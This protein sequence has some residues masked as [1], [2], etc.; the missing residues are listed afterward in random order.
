MISFADCG[1][2]PSVVETLRLHGIKEATPVQER[3]IPEVRAGRDVI[4]QAQTGTGKTL[5]FLLPIFEKIKAQADVAQA[6][7]VTPTRELAIQIAKVAGRLGE[8]AGIPGVDIH[9]V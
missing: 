4:V 9:G 1:L 5:A 7:V 3:A 2:A 8:A 6:L